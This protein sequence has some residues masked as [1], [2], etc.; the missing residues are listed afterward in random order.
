MKNWSV[1]ITMVVFFISGVKIQAQQET[2]IIY[3]DTINVW[4]GDHSHLSNDQFFIGK[5]DAYD[6]EKQLLEYFILQLTN[7]PFFTIDS[8]YGHI[9]TRRKYLPYLCEVGTFD[10]KVWVS[11]GQQASSAN[12][13]IKFESNQ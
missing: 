8:K 13:L 10:L 3:S 2:E 7:K 1:I 5:V 6:P 12:I 11:D 9:Y 4:V